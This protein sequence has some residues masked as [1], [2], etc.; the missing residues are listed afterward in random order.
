MNLTTLE[1]NIKI[2]LQLK[3]IIMNKLVHIERKE[4]KNHHFLF[5]DADFSIASIERLIKEG[6]NDAEETILKNK[7]KEKTDITSSTST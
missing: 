3:K 1:I 6:E 2:F 5:E 7:E 4:S